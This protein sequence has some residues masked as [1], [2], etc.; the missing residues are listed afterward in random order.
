MAKGDN[1]EREETVVCSIVV[2]DTDDNDADPA[3]SMKITIKDNS[4]TAVVDDQ[5]MTK[6]STGHYSYKYTSGSTAKKG[7]YDVLYIAIDGTDKTR[8]RDFFYITK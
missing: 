3:T 4:L 2:Q 5:D 1:F 6:D 8:H 7:R